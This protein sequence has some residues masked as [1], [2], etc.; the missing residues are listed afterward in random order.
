MRTHPLPPEGWGGEKVGEVVGMGT[1]EG[2]DLNDRPAAGYFQAMEP[3][4]HMF[5]EPMRCGLESNGTSTK[6]I[7]GGTFGAHE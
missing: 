7:L 5:T 2:P 4:R 3:C 1:A 6:F